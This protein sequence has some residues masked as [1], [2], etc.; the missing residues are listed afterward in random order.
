VARFVIVLAFACVSRVW[1]VDVIVTSKSTVALLRESCFSR[2]L[3]SFTSDY[4]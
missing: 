1:F 2:M 4:M 3:R